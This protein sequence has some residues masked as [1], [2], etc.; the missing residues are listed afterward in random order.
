MSELIEAVYNLMQYFK[1]N[2]SSYNYAV[3]GAHSSS[4][5]DLII[6]NDTTSVPANWIDRCDYTFQI[7]SRSKSPLNAKQQIKDIFSIVDRY[8]DVT[9]PATTVTLDDGSSVELSEVKAYQ[10]I[11]LQRP[12]WFGYDQNGFAKYVFNLKVTTK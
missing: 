3:N 1:D 2:F 5:N 12:H 7:F 9:L 6:I 10:M 4:P 11:P 8:F